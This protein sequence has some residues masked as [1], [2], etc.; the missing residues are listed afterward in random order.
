MQEQCTSCRLLLALLIMVCAEGL[1]L[2]LHYDEAK[3]VASLEHLS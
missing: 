1:L 3:F 2:V